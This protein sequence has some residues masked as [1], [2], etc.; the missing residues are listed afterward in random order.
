MRYHSSLSSFLNPVKRRIMK[1]IFPNT[2]CSEKKRIPRLRRL[3]SETEDPE[4]LRVTTLFAAV[5][6]RPAQPHQAGARQ[7]RP[8]LTAGSRPGLLEK[9]VQHGCSRGMSYRSFSPLFTCC[10]SLWENGTGLLPDHCICNILL[11]IMVALR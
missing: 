11:C 3:S 1:R 6:L 8:R 5:T 9:I 10:G 2:A 7:M 4:I